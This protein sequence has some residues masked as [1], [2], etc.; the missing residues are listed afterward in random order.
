ME[1][2]KL[3]LQSHSLAKAP[4]KAPFHICTLV[5]FFLKRSLNCISFMHCDY[6]LEPLVTSGRLFLHI[7]K[8]ANGHRP[9]TSF[10]RPAVFF[11]QTLAGLAP[12]GSCL[13]F[14]VTSSK[15]PS[16]NTL[17][18]ELWCLSQT[19]LF[20]FH[21]NFLIIH[22]FAYS[23]AAAPSKTK[24]PQEQERCLVHCCISGI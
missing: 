9:E 19:I 17:P 8:L 6:K 1:F 14:S 12:H 7:A 21:D 20:Y 15:R 23:S 3:R 18:K 5:L 4:S 22:L 2:M 10:P 16:L 13:A 24:V 11:P